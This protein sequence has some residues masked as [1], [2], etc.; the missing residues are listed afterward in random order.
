MIISRNSDR[1]RPGSRIGVASDCD[2][3]L[4]KAGSAKALANSLRLGIA[5]EIM[6]IPL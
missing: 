2:R 5:S 3:E 4:L 6:Q 1:D